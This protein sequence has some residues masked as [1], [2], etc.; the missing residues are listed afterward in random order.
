MKATL[1]AL[2]PLVALMACGGSTGGGAGMSW[3]DGGSRRTATFASGARTISSMTDLF[4]VTGS[5]PSGTALSLGV[6]MVPPLVPGTYAC[7]VTQTRTV[8]TF[9]SN[10][11]NV[12]EGC[13]I[14]VASIGATTGEHVTGTFSGTLTLMGGGRRVIT[15]GTFDVPL[16]VTSLAT[17]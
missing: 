11:S 17:P 14:G 1:I 4:Q 15:D 6:A 8:T 7:G 2:A 16:T 13:T 9:A 10:D 12:F 5:E 3:V